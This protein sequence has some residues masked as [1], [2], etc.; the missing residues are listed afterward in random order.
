MP[1][2]DR[3]VDRLAIL[4]RAIVQSGSPAE[5]A[6]FQKEFETICMEHRATLMQISELTGRPWQLPKAF[7]TSP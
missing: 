5:S 1:V 2:V 3:R 7:G 4:K 6:A